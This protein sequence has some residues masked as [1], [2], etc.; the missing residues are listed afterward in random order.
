MIA[1]QFCLVALPTLSMQQGQAP[2]YPKLFHESQAQGSASPDGEA[3]QHLTTFA[4]SVV[5]AVKRMC[6]PSILLSDY[7]GMHYALCMLD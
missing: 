3:C 2:H 6:K 4:E 5:A 1:L 7:Q